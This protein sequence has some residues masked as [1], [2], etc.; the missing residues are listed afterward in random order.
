[1]INDLFNKI[2]NKE[3]L[4]FDQAKNVMDNIMGGK[5]S[6]VQIAGLLVALRMKG[7]SIDEIS[8]MAS[9]M[10][11]HANSINPQGET[12][13]IVGTGGDL[14][15]SYNI[16]T[17]AAIITASCGCIVAKHGNRSVSSKCGS[18]DVLEELGVNL[19][20]TP[21]QVEDTI[22]KVGIGFMF[23]PKFHGAMKH[24]IT[25]RKELG[26]R[27]VFNILGPLTNPASATYEL[28]GVFDPKLTEVMA[29]VLKNLGLQRALVVHGEGGIDEISITGKTKVS[30]LT[31]SGEIKTYN[32]DPSDYGIKKATL[33]D[34]KGG[35]AKDNAQIIL[36][37][38][39]GKE[40][41]AKRDIAVINSAAALIAANKAK[42]F[43]NAIKIV[44]EAIDSGKAKMKLEQLVKYTQ[45][46]K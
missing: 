30:E 28:L 19:E 17:T 6:P 44:E 25:P 1:M 43:D 29:G 34:I 12:V 10:R 36:S 22:N 16:S 3:D 20:L 23:A 42:D 40:K 15:H 9:S 37:I 2:L 41:G 26:I 18:A 31:N 32:F 7:E 21:E 38:L 45:G 13:D 8:G 27:T 14:S 24:A 35:D 4:S 46:L 11:K 39:N 5:L 33:N